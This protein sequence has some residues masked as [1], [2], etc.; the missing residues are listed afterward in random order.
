MRDSDSTPLYGSM[1]S[2]ITPE[3]EWYSLA[4][5]TTWYMA[6]SILCRFQCGRG[7]W[8]Q[9][10]CGSVSAEL[11]VLII[12]ELC[13]QVENVLG[14]PHLWTA[15]AG[16]IYLPRVQICGPVKF[17]CPQ[18]GTVCHLLCMTIALYWTCLDGSWTII[19]LLLLNIVWCHLQML[20]LT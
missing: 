17:K 11:L 2:Y 10:L 8:L 9:S 1:L 15:S 3:D 6:F 13:L 16:C 18:C 19:S 12:Q 14:H 20:W 4:C 7:S 5:D